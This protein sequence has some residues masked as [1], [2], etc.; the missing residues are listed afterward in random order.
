MRA[1][2]VNP[3]YYTDYTEIMEVIEKIERDQSNYSC[4][5]RQWSR[6]ESTELTKTA[7]KKIKALWAR[8]DNLFPEEAE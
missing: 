4:T 1:S 5:S 3:S 8:I 7:A 6:G 2:N